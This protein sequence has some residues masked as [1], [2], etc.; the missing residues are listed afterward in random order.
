MKIVLLLPLAIL[1]PVIREFFLVVISE[2]PSST[3][4][5]FE[6]IEKAP[7]NATDPRP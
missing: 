3:G 7:T 6:N 2:I 1:T 5:T 4:D